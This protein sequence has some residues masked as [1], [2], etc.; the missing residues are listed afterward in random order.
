MTTTVDACV[1]TDGSD[2][3]VVVGAAAAADDDCVPGDADCVSELE[4][5]LDAALEPETLPGLE[6]VPVSCTEK[7]LD[8][9]PGKKVSTERESWMI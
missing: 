8:P 4:S 5:E 1:T 6:L 9:P 2:A 3:F 7:V